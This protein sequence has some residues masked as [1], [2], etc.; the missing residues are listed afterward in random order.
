[1]EPGEVWDGTGGEV[2]FAL[3]LKGEA[4]LGNHRKGERFQIRGQYG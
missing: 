4:G 1:M 2:R 3:S